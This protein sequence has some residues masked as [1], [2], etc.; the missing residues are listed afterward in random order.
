MLGDTRLEDDLADLYWSFVNLFHR[1]IER[2]Q[3]TLDSI[4][5]ARRRAQ[6]EQDGSE[7]KS[8]ELECLI[9]QGLTLIEQRNAFEFMRDNAAELFEAHTG[10]VWKPFSGS[11]VSHRTLTAA[12][13]ESRDYI[14][15]KRRSETEIFLPEG[16]RILFTGGIDYQDHERIWTALDIVK[17]KHSDM[18]LLHGGAPRGAELIAAKWADN[19]DVAQVVFKPDWTKHQKAAPFKRNDV[20]L[21]A[22]SIGVIAFP[23]YDITGNLVDTARARHIPVLEISCKAAPLRLHRHRRDNLTLYRS[24]LHLGNDQERSPRPSRQPVRMAIGCTACH[25][26]KMEDSAATVART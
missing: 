22:M 15:A 4:E 12:V 9:A 10:S 25:R 11:K 3:R 17:A 5:D 24:A 13:I 26:N 18:V 6:R 8:V 21:E 2:V 1:K 7:I 20:M 19:R 23:G 16:P 14:N